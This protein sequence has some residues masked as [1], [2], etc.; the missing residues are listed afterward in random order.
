[1]KIK[2]TMAN[3]PVTLARISQMY[4]NEY[5]EYKFNFRYRQIF[6]NILETKPN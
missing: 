3:F 6:A 2:T 4:T 5:F 1:M